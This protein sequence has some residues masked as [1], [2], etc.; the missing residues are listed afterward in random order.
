MGAVN[1]RFGVRMPKT[2]KAPDARPY[3]H[4]DLRRSLIDA[5]LTL[6]TEKQDW[7]FSLREIARRAGVSHNAPYNHFADADALLIAIAAAGFERMREHLSAAVSGVV[8][9]DE[10]LLACGKA[11]IELA[12]KN[13]ALYR[14]MCGPALAK[15][16]GSRPAEAR[17]AADDARSVLEDIIRRGARSGAF[18][19]SP[20]ESRDQARVVFFTWSVVHGLSMALLDGFAGTEIAVD[21][22]V[23]LVERAVLDGL[24]PRK[25]R[26]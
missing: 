7:T 19:V 3:H 18:A 9:P 20:D 25:G 4:G 22:L 15:S 13:P 8:S 12:L 16:T 23:K 17:T 10:A 11:Y 14:L 1:I 6:V 5:G 21:D 24:R 2:E 26:R